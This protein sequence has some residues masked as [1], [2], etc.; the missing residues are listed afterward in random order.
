MPQVRA[1]CSRR[2]RAA[3]PQQIPRRE[4]TPRDVQIEIL[5]CGICH[6][7]CTMARSEWVS[8]PAV[9]PDACRAT[10]SSGG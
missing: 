8:F 4:P 3:R 2:H 1:A 5:Y 10:R 9:Y 7:T 6:R